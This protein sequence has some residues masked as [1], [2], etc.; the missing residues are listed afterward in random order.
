M[1]CRPMAAQTT[2][3]DGLA[4]KCGCGL[5]DGRLL[6]NDSAVNVM[7]AFVIKFGGGLPGA[8]LLTSGQSDNAVGGPCHQIW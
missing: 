2:P 4:I 6:A 3:L 8:M 5:P 1:C 7:V